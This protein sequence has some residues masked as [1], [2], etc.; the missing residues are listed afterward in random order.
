MEFVFLMIFVGIGVCVFISQLKEAKLYSAVRK[1]GIRV[2]GIVQSSYI[3]LSPTGNKIGRRV[4]PENVAMVEFDRQSLSD[5]G[6]PMDYPPSEVLIGSAQFAEGDE[7][8]C[9]YL[10]DSQTMVT[11]SAVKSFY[12][13]GISFA[14]TI[15]VTLLPPVCALGTVMEIEGGFILFFLAALFAAIGV[16]GIIPVIGTL[17]TNVVRLQGEICGVTEKHVSRKREFSYEYSFYYAN[18]LYRS[19][20]GTYRTYVLLPPY[21][22]KPIKVYFNT[23]TEEFIEK[24]DVVT[25]LVMS[26]IFFAVVLLLI[27]M[28]LG[29][30]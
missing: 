7:I 29:R 22:G 12:E 28:A 5:A 24:N 25:K 3:R 19:P 9:I 16:F 15:A 17:S 21:I 23:E 2:S 6:L 14:I 27:L 4:K 1:R 30:I 10:P 11:R 20:C 13:L 18:K 26:L 8:N